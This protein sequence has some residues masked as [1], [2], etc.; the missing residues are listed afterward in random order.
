MKVFI[1]ALASVAFWAAP[2]LSK[3]VE[4]RTFNIPES[5]TTV[6]IPSSVF[7]DDGG[8]PE[9]LGQSSSLRMAGPI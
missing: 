2:V 8:R 3:A 7:T 9:G 4:W 5:G 6:D 1:I